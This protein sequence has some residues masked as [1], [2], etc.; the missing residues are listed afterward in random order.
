MFN[1]LN[2]RP[3]LIKYIEIPVAK[4]MHKCGLKPNHITG[5]SL[6]LCILSGYLVISQHLVAAGLIFFLGSC[7]DLFD[8][9]LSRLTSSS[10]E[11]GALLDSLG[12][13]IGESVLLSA[14]IM[15]AVINSEQI[16]FALT[17]YNAVYML[18]DQT[19]A[20]LIPIGLIALVSSQLVSYV[21][22]RGESLGTSMESGLMTRAERVI[23]VSLGLVTGYIF[24]AILLMAVFSSFTLFQ[25][26]YIISTNTQTVV[27]SE[28]K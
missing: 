11:F 21:R 13:R 1:K 24:L 19:N 12:D 3:I 25:R 15:L 7:L 28:S 17:N 8:G 23:L 2:I 6:L 16:T 20:Y 4:C 10:T 27:N 18:T 9:T 5:L 26:I 22:A 14:I